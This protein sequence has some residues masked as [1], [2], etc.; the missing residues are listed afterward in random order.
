MRV[1]RRTD[2]FR[3]EP[4]SSL[5]E[6]AVRRLWGSQHKVCV[7]AMTQPPSAPPSAPTDLPPS[8]STAELINHEEEGII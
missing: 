4:E 7:V 6:E 1:H 2:V 3:E 8:R 5:E